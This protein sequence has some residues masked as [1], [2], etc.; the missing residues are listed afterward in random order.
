MPGRKYSISCVWGCE[1]TV[2]S[3]APPSVMYRRGADCCLDREV[4]FHELFTIMPGRFAFLVALRLDFSCSCE[5]EP[6]SKHSSKLFHGIRKVRDACC[7][8][9]IVRASA[10]TCSY[11]RRNIVR[12][13][14][15]EIK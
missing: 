2:G 11:F 7:C 12:G 6:A 3:R 9:W 8:I 1:M 5:S 4:L 15:T 14:K 13:H 10:C